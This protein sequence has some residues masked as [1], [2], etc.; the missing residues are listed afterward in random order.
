MDLRS[1]EILNAILVK[2]LEELTP[3]D[4]V[5]LKARRSYLKKS[6]LIDYESILNP[7]PE[8]YVAKKDRVNQTSTEVEPV[9]TNATTS[10]TN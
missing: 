5:F 9:K 8:I 1:Q 7:E 3:E 6:Q 2:S 10:E 4:K